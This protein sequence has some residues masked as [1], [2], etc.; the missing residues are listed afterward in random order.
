MKSINFLKEYN[1]FVK[2]L[3]LINDIPPVQKKLI[4]KYLQEYELIDWKIKKRDLIKLLYKVKSILLKEFSKKTYLE[5][6]KIKVN[7]SIEKIENCKGKDK[8][9]KSFSFVEDKSNKYSFHDV[10]RSEKTK[11]LIIKKQD[12]YIMNLVNSEIKETKKEIFAIKKIEDI[13]T[14]EKYYLKKKDELIKKT[15]TENNINKI[16][17]ELKKFRPLLKLKKFVLKKKNI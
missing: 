1:L 2:W 6:K 5:N 14:K 9:F 11:E 8:I 12:K 15:I 17:K 13:I 16:F 7:C 4:V 10:I 3:Y